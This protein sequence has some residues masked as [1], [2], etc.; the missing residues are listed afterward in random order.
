MIA[1]IGEGAFFK[2][3]QDTPRGQDMFGS[4]VVVMPTP[5][6]GGQLVLRHN[7]EEW[8]F[9]AAAL[10]SGKAPN[11]LAYIAFF[12]DVEHEVLPVASGYR[13]TLTYNLYYTWDTSTRLYRQGV[14]SIM[15]PHADV[16]NLRRILGG[17]LDDPAFL[18]EG[19]NLGFGL[20][21]RYPFTTPYDGGRDREPLRCLR[22]WLK[23]SD[24]S[25]FQA[26]E[27]LGLNPLLRLIYDDRFGGGHLLLLDAMFA[28]ADAVE[29]DTIA[30]RELLE[31]KRKGDGIIEVKNIT[32]GE[33]DVE[34]DRDDGFTDCPNDD[35]SK[36]KIY[37]VTSWGGGDEVY[38]ERLTYGNEAS[39]EYNYAHVCL[40]AEV[41]PAPDR[42]K[43]SNQG[44]ASDSEDGEGGEGGGGGKDEDRDQD[45]EIVQA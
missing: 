42:T 2:P 37:W 26:C 28:L 24:Y 38:S 15:P 21:H 27:G 7:G 22:R 23:G 6:E 34:D 4:L 25:L 8:T 18:P 45:K 44:S 14:S 19:G 43:S 13:V 33:G 36:V 40:I 3:H 35:D 16:R 29:G 31:N 32:L 41:P 11:T 30:S 9:D 17:L 5:H 39:I 1:M 10:L 20:R 12:S